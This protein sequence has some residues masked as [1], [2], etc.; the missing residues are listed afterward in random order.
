[1]DTGIYRLHSGGFSWPWPPDPGAKRT[2]AA[3]Q[4]GQAAAD[5]A[6]CFKKSQAL[7]CQRAELRYAFM[8]QHHVQWPVAVLCEVLE[9]SRSGFYAYRQRHV[10]GREERHEL[11]L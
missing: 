7:L 6:G 1:M 2:P 10:S 8:A 3:P 5:G 4:R 9:V 11:A